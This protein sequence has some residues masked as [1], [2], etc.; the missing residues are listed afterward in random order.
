[1]SENPIRQE[2]LG[3]EDE[4]ND[5]SKVNISMEDQSQMA[6]EIMEDNFLT[7]E[8]IVSSEQKMNH[9]PNSVQVVEGVEKSP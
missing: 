5:I 4:I 1:V 2:Q 8:D 7:K 9:H 3:E 6:L